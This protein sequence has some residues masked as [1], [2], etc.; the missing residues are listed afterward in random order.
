MEITKGKLLGREEYGNFELEFIVDK[1]TEFINGKYVESLYISPIAGDGSDR[2]FFRIKLDSKSFILMYALPDNP[3][4]LRENEAFSYF[5][6]YLAS[7]GISVPRIYHSDPSRGFF[8]LE[9]LGNLSLHTYI[10][11]NPGSRHTAF[12]KAVRLLAQFHNLDGNEVDSRFFIDTEHYNPPF[13]L[14]RELE[15]F[16]KSFLCDFLGLPASWNSLK[17]DF[18]RLSELA[19]TEETTSLIHRDFQ[20]RNIMVKKGKLRLIDYQGMRY[21]PGEYDLASLLIDPY[22]GLNLSE[23]LS[24]IKLYSRLRKKF[25]PSRY[26]TVSLCR[27]LQILAAF[28][29]LGKKKKKNFFLD[30]IPRA[31]KELRRKRSH[32][33]RLNLSKL[34]FWLDIGESI[35][36]NLTR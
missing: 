1:V 35:M 19:G 8:I 33:R 24:L 17:D 6:T 12:K 28:A 22:V 30:F 21:G 16:R 14:E 29:F 3:F 26:E 31:W 27:N 25:S 9:D 4:R 15:Y 34:S 7:H 10:L 20:S 11:K 2:R 36:K 32:L 13:V 5:S 18:F 23:R